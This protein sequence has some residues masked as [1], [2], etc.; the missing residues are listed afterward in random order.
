MKTQPRTGMKRTRVPFTSKLRPELTYEI[1]PDRKGR[2][3]MLL[4]TPML[5]AQEIS[6]VPEGVLITVPIL[7]S[8]LANHHGADLVCPLMTG[9]FFNII[10]GAAEEQ[11]AAGESPVAPYWRVVLEDGTLSPKTPDG[12]ERHA[13]RLRQ[14]GHTI[15]AK[16]SKL[17]VADFE[18]RL[19]E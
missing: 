18:Q 7:R 9:I 3:Q 16:G 4:P 10:A 17:K 12:P 5:V 2:G 14:E 15:V 6:S 8:R 11:L 13:E 19:I 1:A